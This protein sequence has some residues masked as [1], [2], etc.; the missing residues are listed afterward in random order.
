M[1]KRDTDKREP[2]SQKMKSGAEKWGQL[3]LFVEQS[4]PLTPGARLSFLLPWPNEKG[5]EEK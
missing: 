1:E 4:I 2:T 5:V 3:S